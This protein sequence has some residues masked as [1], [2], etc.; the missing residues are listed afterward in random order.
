MFVCSYKVNE[1]LKTS[2]GTKREETRKALDYSSTSSFVQSQYGEHSLEMA[3]LLFLGI[4]IDCMIPIAKW[5][6]YIGDPTLADAIMDRLVANA[7]KIE[8]THIAA[9][10][11]VTH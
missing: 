2:R 1:S 9:I 7:N 3:F 11:H 5:Y 8:L 10:N 4:T 6:D